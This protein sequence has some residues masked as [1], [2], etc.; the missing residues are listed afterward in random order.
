MPAAAW[1]NSGQLSGQQIRGVWWA[2]PLRTDTGQPCF[3]ISARVPRLRGVP[4]P[5][6]CP[7]CPRWQRARDDGASMGM[8]ESAAVMK[9]KSARRSRRGGASDVEAAVIGHGRLEGPRREKKYDG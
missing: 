8:L 7:R 4:S 5:D 3:C 9:P 1:C 2:G 6:L